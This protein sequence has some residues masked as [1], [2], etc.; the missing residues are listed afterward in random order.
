MPPHDLY[1]RH[2]C[3]EP[4]SASRTIE[5]TCEAIVELLDDGTK[6][7]W[8]ET[9]K[10]WR[11]QPHAHRELSTEAAATEYEAAEA[12]PSGPKARWSL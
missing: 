12:A 4:R 11:L 9:A 1:R 3:E 6:L 2:V 10:G 7:E 5:C 8:V